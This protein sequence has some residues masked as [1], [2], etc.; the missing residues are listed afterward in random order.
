MAIQEI[1]I[2]T[3]NGSLA[4]CTVSRAGGFSEK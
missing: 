3:S 1:S 4:T 2:G